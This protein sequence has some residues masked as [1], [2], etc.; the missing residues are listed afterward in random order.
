MQ[1]NKTKEI[2]LI[3]LTSV[4]FILLAMNSMVFFSRM[5]LTKNKTFTISNTTKRIISSL[6]DRIH[7]TYFI[8][9]KIKAITPVA[10]EIEDI[11]YEYAAH[12]KGRITVN[13]MD[14]ATSGMV[15]RAES[16]G[17]IPQQIEIY[18]QNEKSFTVV[19]SGIVIQYMDKI[20]TIPFTIALE[21][22]EYELTYRIRKLVEDIDLSLGILIGDSGKSIENHYSYLNDILKNNY[23]IEIIKPGQEI[24]A[25]ISVLAVLG[26]KDLT[27]GDMLY[28]D[29]YIMDGGK[30][31]FAM[32][33]VD[34]DARN[35]VTAV[36]LE[37]S[38]A[39]EMLKKYGI[40]VNNDLVLDKYA[41]RIPLRGMFPMQYPQWISILGQNVSKDNPITARFSGLDL[42][43]ASSISIEEM[44]GIT[45]ERLLATTDQ[46]WTLDDYITTSPQ[47][48]S[49]LMRY[50]GN[51]QRQ[52]ALGYA[53]SGT[54]KSAF[55]NKTG[56]NTRIIV[57]GDSEFA[58]DIIEFS[59][60]HYNII[61]FENA[62]EWLSSDDSFLQIK[63]RDRRDL[64]LNKIEKPERRN[65]AILFVHLVNIVIIPLSIIIFAIVHF[66]RRKIREV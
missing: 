16:L 22:I 30:V 11:L 24:P 2:I 46:A 53:A 33:G 48:V 21:T 45:Y 28:V 61:F 64:R 62:I 17:I 7:I 37:N 6:P 20:E 29:E 47:E 12:S 55:T 40:T 32:E 15:S 25:S 5:D 9:D 41:K 51:D 27:D 23:K 19:Y 39:I 13:S 26:N 52:I 43:W 57:I 66:I 8:S 35:L 38:P 1:K 58:A 56:K 49:S 63:T 36:K 31:L 50:K 10:L 42:L 44:E 54:F 18:E 3:I 4:I 60:S 34:V 65:I 59:D 14:P